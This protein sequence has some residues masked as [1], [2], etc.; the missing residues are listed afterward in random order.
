MA[1]P[2]HREPDVIDRSIVYLPTLLYF[3]AAGSAAIDLV[4]NHRAARFLA[5]LVLAA[6]LATRVATFLE[7]G[8]CPMNLA[9]GGLG[10]VALV[11][12]LTV[13]VTTFVA[14]RNAA[15]SLLLIGITGVL[16]LLSQVVAKRPNDFTPPPQERAL[17]EL[18][19]GIVLLAYAAFVVAAVHASLYLVQY[20]TMKRRRLGFWFDR[21]PPLAKLESRAVSAEYVGLALLTVGL[22]IGFYMYFVFHGGVPWTEVKFVVAMMLWGWSATGFFLR[23]VLRWHGI[24]LMWLPALGLVM[25]VLVYSVA[26]GHPF[27]SDA[28]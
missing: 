3:A 8:L 28:A 2:L 4:W 14:E 27:W 24:R 16:D 12:A 7:P 26:G 22:A 23:R 6:A 18:H 5:A 17:G 20:W 19:G 9:G 21:L 10:I 15:K 25:L 1:A 11:L 13:L